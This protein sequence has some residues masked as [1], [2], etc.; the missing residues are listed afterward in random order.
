MM[1]WCHNSTIW[2]HNS[3]TMATI[4]SKYTWQPFL[5]ILIAWLQYITFGDFWEKTDHIYSGR[6]LVQ[7][8]YLVHYLAPSAVIQALQKSNFSL[9]WKN[10]NSWRHSQ[11]TSSV[12][13]MSILET[14]NELD[15][16]VELGDIHCKHNQFDHIF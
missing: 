3:S 9:K 7:Q 15:V 4:N 14:N 16:P 6:Q 13:A 1:T 10:M 5:H 11:S 12:I 2:C 8:G